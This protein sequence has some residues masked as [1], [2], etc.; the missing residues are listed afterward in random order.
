[1]KIN[2]RFFEE[3]HILCLLFFSCC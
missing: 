2:S 1:M 3:F